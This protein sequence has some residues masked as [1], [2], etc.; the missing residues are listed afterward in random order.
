STFLQ[1]PRGATRD[2]N[3]AR[4]E[5]ARYVLQ[6]IYRLSRPWLQDLQLP[7]IATSKQRAHSLARATIKCGLAWPSGRRARLS[8]RR[9][10]LKIFNLSTHTETQFFIASNT[11]KLSRWSGLELA[12]LSPRR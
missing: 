2:V 3:F 10:Q 9:S 1:V 5:R 11:I 4:S 6:T 8:P 7:A 12:F